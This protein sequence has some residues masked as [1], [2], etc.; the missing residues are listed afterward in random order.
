MEGRGR[1]RHGE[2]EKLHRKLFMN[3]MD[4]L[5]DLSLSCKSVYGISI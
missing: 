4:S 1:G 3:M 2:W 5:Q